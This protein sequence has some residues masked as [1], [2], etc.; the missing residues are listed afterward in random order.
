MGIALGIGNLRL[1]TSSPSWASYWRTQSEV[2]FFASDPVNIMNKVVDG[3]INN[4]KS[5]STDY[6]TVTGEGLNARYRTP[7]TQEYKDADTDYCFWKS[8]GDESVCDGNR[9]IGYDFTRTI[10]FYLDVSPYTIKAIMIL[11]SDI[12]VGAKQNKMRDDFHLSCWWSGLLSFHGNVKQNRGLSKSTWTPEASYTAP[13]NLAL[14]T[15]SDTEISGTFDDTNIDIDGYSFEISSNGIDYTAKGTSATKTLLATT[16]T[17]N[18]QYWIRVRAYKVIGGTT[19]YGEYSNAVN[20][21]TAHLWVLSKY[22]TGAGVGAF[23]LK[24]SEAVK[25]TLDGSG[26]FYS[27]AGGT[28]NESQEWNVEANTL[29]VMYVKVTSGTSNMRVF[30]KNTLIQLGSTTVDGYK[31]HSTISGSPSLAV[32]YTKCTALISILCSSPETITLDLSKYPNLLWIR[33]DGASNVTGD[34]SSLTTLTYIY[35]VFATSISGDIGVNN[36]V[37]GITY[38]RIGGQLVNYTSGAVWSNATINI[39]P[40]VG[41]GFNIAALSAIL[42]DMYNSAVISSKA[43]TLTGSSASMADTNQGG[44]WGDYSGAAAPSTLATAFKNLAKTRSNTVTL[45]GITI[46]GGSDDGVGFP[47][48]FGNWYRL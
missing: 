24:F 10:I 2:L 3:K 21:W 30:H 25:I 9:L 5:G 41:Y 1:G 19:F 42:I 26:Y 32:D 14:T 18:T 39:Q 47:A 36:V 44:I 45:K 20:T 40:S 23:D 27:D 7:N 33:A 12:A 13:T 11:S 38:F 4:Q 35:L 29:S 48:G 22:G 17:N 28:L 6:L 8:N 43:I 15:V 37:N 46:P 34:I 16:L 31:G